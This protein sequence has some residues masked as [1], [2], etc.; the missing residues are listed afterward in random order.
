MFGNW[1]CYVVSFRCSMI[2]SVR[3]ESAAENLIILLC[4]REPRLNLYQYI[5]ECCVKKHSLK[6]IQIKDK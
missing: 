5:R 6:I 2:I 4:A 1:E 3:K